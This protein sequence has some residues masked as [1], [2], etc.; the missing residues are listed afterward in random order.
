LA[1]YRLQ[2][3][4]KNPSGS[5][6]L[7][8]CQL[9]EGFLHLYPLTADCCVFSVLMLDKTIYDK[10]QNYCAYRERCKSEVVSK[11][12]TLKV[13]KPDFEVYLEKLQEENFLNEDRFVKSYVS[14]YS[15]KKWGK[16][17]I[18]SALSGKRIDS[19]LIKKYLDD[20]DE[21][22]YEEQIKVAAEKKLRSIK[23]PSQREVKTKLLRFLLGKG[24]E[25]GKILLV[26]KE[27]KL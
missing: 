3:Y 16:V 4:S 15:K 26:L 18:K 27:L 12:M 20:L 22:N 8:V 2:R 13:E 9:P 14:A 5:A 21:G 24:Y 17:K 11:M 10:L 23:A 19:V 7:N 6:G 1:K 25:M